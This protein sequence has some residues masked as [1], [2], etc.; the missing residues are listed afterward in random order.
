MGFEIPINTAYPT[1][2]KTLKLIA[3]L[4]RPEADIYPIRLWAWAAEYARDG[5]VKGGGAQ[6]ELAVGWRGEPGRLS[7]ALVEA[8]FIE[9]D[10]QTIHDWH[11][12]TGRSILIYERKKQKQREKYDKEHGILP[13]DFRQNSPNPNNN[14]KPWIS[15]PNNPTEPHPSN[16][17]D[18][19]VGHPILETP[20]YHL[21]MSL[22]LSVGFRGGMADDI[23][24]TLR[25]RRIVEVIEASKSQQKP[26]GWAR[27]AFK[28]GWEV[29]A[30]TDAQVEISLAGVKSNGQ[31]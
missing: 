3:L 18:S 31:H 26:A 7:R 10:G 1:H 16:G 28:E 30:L 29:P 27:Q 14:N 24:R 12:H 21:G 6:I 19:V 22:L 15:N 13:E 5:V 25:I 9:V 8:E 23:A 2:P 20:D 4:R 17:N 11:E